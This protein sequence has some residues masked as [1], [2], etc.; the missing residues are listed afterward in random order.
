MRATATR[1]TMA[2]PRVVPVTMKDREAGFRASVSDPAMTAVWATR[3][4]SDPTATTIDATIR[5]GRAQGRF[6]A[7]Q[8]R[9]LCSRKKGT[10]NRTTAPLYSSQRS[11]MTA[12]SSMT[13]WTV[14][15]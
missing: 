11:P 9:K 14:K 13:Y 10:P 6:G 12:I 2:R 8:S 3:A 5:V 4:T 15:L 1:M 7:S